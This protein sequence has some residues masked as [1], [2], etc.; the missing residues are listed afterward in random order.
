[1]EVY[2]AYASNRRMMAFT[3]LINVFIWIHFDCYL[4]KVMFCIYASYAMCLCDMDHVIQTLI[5]ASLTLC[6]ASLFF[7]FLILRIYK[8]LHIP[9]VS[10]FPVN[11]KL[12][13]TFTSCNQQTLMSKAYIQWTSHKL[14][15]TWKVHS[16]YYLYC[17]YF[18]SQCV[19]VHKCFQIS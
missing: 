17:A 13:I 18:T 15:R 1:M 4:E 2:N 16:I 19:Y 11:I 10:S 5:Y 9:T 8:V 14:W 7:C 6:S 3:I 12:Y